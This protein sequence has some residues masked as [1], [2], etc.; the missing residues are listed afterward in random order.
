[1][2]RTTTFARIWIGFGAAAASAVSLGALGALS[3]ARQAPGFAMAAIALGGAL[4]LALGAWA[5][6]SARRAA[7]A[8]SEEAARVGEAVAAGK[9]DARFEVSR[10][11]PEARGALERTNGALESLSRSL[12]AL[13]G[14]LACLSRGE[15]PSPK[16]A[17]PAV[18]HPR[19]KEALDGA[20][21]AAAA[22]WDE[23]RALAAAAGAEQPDLR[24]EK[25]HS[26]RFGEAVTGVQ[27]A[28]QR[29]KE[30]AHW[31]QEILDALPFHLSV[32]DREMRWTY[33]NAPVE[34]FLGVKRR[35]VLGKPC[36]NW[37]ADNCRTENCG[38]ARLRK[39]LST[40]T[41][42]QEGR[43]FRVDAALLKDPKGETVGHLEVVQ[44]VTP[45]A[46]LTEYQR[47]ELERLSENLVQL[48]AGD[49][50]IET[51]VA[52]GDDHTREAHEQFLAA[53]KSLDQVRSAMAAL[54]LDSTRL[55][56]AAVAGRL[57]ERADASAHRGEYRKAVEGV[58]RLLDA[59]TAPIHEASRALDQL[60]LRDLHARVEGSYPGDHAR[61]K[62]SV[63]AAAQALHDAL[64]QVSEAVEQVSSAATQ[65]AA[66]SQAVASGASEQAAS[67]EE[68]SSSIESVASMTKQSA[69]NAQQA[70]HLAE[71]ARAAAGQGT[72]AVEQMQS[73]MAR[74]RASAEGTS[75]IIRDIN[76]I[77]FQTNLLALNA[78]VEAAR[79]GEAGRGFAVVAEEVRSLALRAKEAAMKTEELIRQSVKEAGQGEVTAKEVAGKL[80]EIASGISKV[81]D[82]ICEIAAGAKEQASGIDRVNRSVAE[83][84]KVT[85]QNAASAEESSS[86]ASE[87]SSQAEEL[88]SMIAGF[89]LDRGGRGAE[90]PK[91]A[92]PL[93]PAAPHR[94]NGSNGAQAPS[95]PHPRD[96]RDAERLFPMDDP[97]DIRDF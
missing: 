29:L 32:T 23:L 69:D 34:R 12:E 62:E 26:G 19:A 42:R 7:R 10:L 25:N 46:R 80:A 90:P 71:V 58:N 47:A 89:K 30:R 56:D 40:T 6:A 67:L 31:Y 88:A 13:T 78:A 95:P 94:R 63:N 91:P 17:R 53:A 85:Q 5:A 74:I 43:H 27:K 59:V 96:G 15:L 44:D 38:I 35:E 84:D 21:A 61:M 82:I 24:V 68:T 14:G 18:L 77:A 87:L 55:A 81:T 83:M 3:A 4:V 64:A 75:Q 73:A 57:S 45:L 92:A 41:F 9:L 50:A 70:N 8:L 16:G 39:G 49:L 60:A 51:E 1:M 65:I 86:A 2:T 79:A 97:G 66:S 28:L 11:S 48:A 93:P 72:S 37:N 22:C 36:E 54:V 52:E 76:D 33:V 20:T